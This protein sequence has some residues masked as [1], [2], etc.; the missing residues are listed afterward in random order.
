[1]ILPFNLFIP[2]CWSFGIPEI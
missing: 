1:L 2:V